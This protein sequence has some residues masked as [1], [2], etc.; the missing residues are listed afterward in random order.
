MTDRAMSV[1]TVLKTFLEVDLLAKTVNQGHPAK[2]CQVG[3]LEETMD[4]SDTFG[5]VA[6]TILPVCFLQQKLYGFYYI[7]SSSE[8]KIF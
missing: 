8:I 7:Y 1:Q 6:Q 4:F 2:V 3:S 5:H